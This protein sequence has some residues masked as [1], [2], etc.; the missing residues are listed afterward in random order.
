M[1][2]TASD[3]AQ[4]AWADTFR[5]PTDTPAAQAGAEPLSGGKS[6]K[7]PCAKA[8]RSRSRTSGRFSPLFWPAFETG[9][10]AAAG[11]AGLR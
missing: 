6:A 7:R 11:A 9:R 8:S 2:G 3:P 4:N 10:D 5:S 1:E